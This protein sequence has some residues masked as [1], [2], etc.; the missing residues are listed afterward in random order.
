M[1]GLTGS[2]A[3]CNHFKW[4]FLG[5]AVSNRPG[6]CGNL[7]SSDIFERAATSHVLSSSLLRF[8]TQSGLLHAN[9]WVQFPFEAVDSVHTMSVIYTLK[10]VRP[11]AHR[12]HNSHHNHWSSS[13]AIRAMLRSFR[14]VWRVC[15][16]PYEIVST[17]CR[18]SR[19]FDPLCWSQIYYRWSVAAD[20]RSVMLPRT[21]GSHI[22]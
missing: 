2:P 20:S 6:N 10:C 4:G 17:S 16:A 13:I 1:A 7:L 12:A 8:D 9:S 3:G 15:C 11:T 5:Q 18:R 22:D 14:R 21:S 19:S